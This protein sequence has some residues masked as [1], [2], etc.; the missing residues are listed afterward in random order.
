LRNVEF[1]NVAFTDLTQGSRAGR[2]GER[3]EYDL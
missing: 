2:V 3:G 1:L